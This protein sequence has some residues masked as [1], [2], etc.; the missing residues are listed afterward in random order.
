[1]EG[2]VKRLPPTL[3]MVSLMIAHVLTNKAYL[4]IGEGISSL[5]KPFRRSNHSKSAKHG[6]ASPEHTIFAAH[7]KRVLLTPHIGSSA[8]TLGILRTDYPTFLEL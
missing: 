4:F 5:K 3:T 1:M 2:K 6:K 7:K 8:N